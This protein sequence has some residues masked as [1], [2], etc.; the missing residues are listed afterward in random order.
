MSLV[1]DLAGWLRWERQ[2]KLSRE[3]ALRGQGGEIASLAWPK[4]LLDQ[5]EG[6]IGGQAYALSRR[7][8]LH[9][10]AKV[11]RAPF[12]DE[13]AIA[14]LSIGGA[15]IELA[16]GAAYE[17]T[18]PSA[19]KTRWTLVDDQGRELASINVPALKARVGEVAVSTEGRREKYLPLLLLISWYVIVP[20]LGQG[21]G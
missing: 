9:P 8:I 11:L 16:H 18:R 12:D 17:L 14:R 20:K 4:P 21:G 19:W 1:Q 15:R 2:G 10:V 7:G 3:Y 5:A 13:V 6:R